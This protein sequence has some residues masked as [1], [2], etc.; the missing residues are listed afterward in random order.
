MIYWSLFI[1]FSADVR[2]V[3]DK[4]LSTPLSSYYTTVLENKLAS[5]Q[6]TDSHIEIENKRGTD[7]EWDVDRAG[8]QIEE[9]MCKPTTRLI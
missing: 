2:G 9:I 4:L 1:H 5:C 8:R 7:G 3:I 6:R